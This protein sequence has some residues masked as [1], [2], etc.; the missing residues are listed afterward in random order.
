MIDKKS[1]PAEIRVGNGALLNLLNPAP[2]LLDPVSVIARPLSR[3]GR[4]A[5][6]TPRGCYSIAEHQVLGA[7]FALVETRSLSVALAFLVHDAHEGPL[8]DWTTPAVAALAGELAAVIGEGAGEELHKAVARIKERL[9]KAI[10]V[11]LGIPSGWPD[12]IREQVHIY[13]KRMFAAE[14]AALWR[15]ENEPP[16]RPSVGEII[17]FNLTDP[18]NDENRFMSAVLAGVTYAGVG[19]HIFPTFRQSPTKAVTFDFN[20]GNM[21]PWSADFAERAWLG[22]LDELKAALA[23]SLRAEISPEMRAKLTAEKNAEKTDNG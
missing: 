10:A 18:D 5:C 8:G 14:K 4:F 11:R 3:A 16:G 23:A 19:A 21:R 20:L 6:Q 7:A 2:A 15:T 22:A 17:R 12:S 13:D 9:D 1:T